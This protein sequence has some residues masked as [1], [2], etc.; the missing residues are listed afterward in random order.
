ML[1]DDPE[2]CDGE[3]ERRAAQEGGDISIHTADA[4]RTAETSTT[5]LAVS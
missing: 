3:E 5:E 4:C 1:C 2:G